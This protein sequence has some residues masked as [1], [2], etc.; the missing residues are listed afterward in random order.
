MFASSSLYLKS[1]SRSSPPLWAT[2]LTRTLITASGEAV[3]V[4]S[5]ATSQHTHLTTSLIILHR[6]GTDVF[7]CNG[8]SQET[9]TL[10]PETNGKMRSRSKALHKEAQSWMRVRERASSFVS[11]TM[12]FRVCCRHNDNRIQLTSNGFTA[13]INLSLRRVTNDLT[14]SVKTKLLI[15]HHSVRCDTHTVDWHT[16]QE[17]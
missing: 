15:A 8:P 13:H 2:A 10:Q 14:P 6:P 3:L 16:V 1:L 12:N 9:R 17:N 7:K 11:I 4:T 5:T